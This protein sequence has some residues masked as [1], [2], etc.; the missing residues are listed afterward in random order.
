VLSSACAIIRCGAT[1]PL[2]AGLHTGPVLDD[3][4]THAARG[5]SETSVS[6]LRRFEPVVFLT[7]SLQA[8]ARAFI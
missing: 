2:I 7:H 4:E 3:I 5:F 8:L 6:L 1:A